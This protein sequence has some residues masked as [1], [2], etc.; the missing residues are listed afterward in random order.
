M[1]QGA[2]MFALVVRIVSVYLFTPVS[3]EADFKST[4]PEYE[5]DQFAERHLL[6]HAP[7]REVI[8]PRTG[9][10]LGSSR[11]IHAPYHF[12]PMF[13]HSG[14][15]L[16]DR[17]V[18]KPATGRLQLPTGLTDLLLPQQ[19]DPK[20]NSFSPVRNPRG[21]EVWCGY[22]HISVRVQR[23]M[24]GFRSVASMFLLGTCPVTR[25]TPVLLYFH[26]NLNDCGSTQMTV[27]GHLVYSNSL[28]YSPLAEGSVIRAVPLHLPIQC[29][30]NRFHYS[31]KVGYVPE[32]HER[33]FLK[34]MKSKRSFRLT[35]CNAEWRH[36]SSEES[37]MLGEPM[38]FEAYAA[39]VPQ[40]YRVFVSS[41]FI[42]PFK[43]PDA[44][45]RFQVIHDFGCMVDSKRQ[46]S[47]SQFF[48][49]EAN[50]LLFS[51]DAFLFP[52]F[53]HK[54]LYLHCNITVGKSIPKPNAKSCTYNRALQRWEELYGS[55]SVCSCCD[56]VCE[57]SEFWPGL[58]PSVKSSITSEP[59][60]V[61]DKSE[62]IQTEA[63]PD[64][65]DRVEE[66]KMFKT[67]A[68][69]SGELDKVAVTPRKE[70]KVASV[71]LTD[72][73]EVELKRVK[74]ISRQDWEEERNWKSLEGTQRIRV[75]EDETLKGMVER[76][77]VAEVEDNM[78]D[79]EMVVV[80]ADE[81]GTDPVPD[82]VPDGLE[83]NEAAPDGMDVHLAEN[84]VTLKK[85]VQQNMS[86]DLTSVVPVNAGV[87]EKVKVIEG[88]RLKVARV[89]VGRMPLKDEEAAF[90]QGYMEPAE[91]KEEYQEPHLGWETSTKDT[92]AVLK[93]S[94][95]AEIT[96]VY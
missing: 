39:F 15:P 80:Q 58:S 61:L 56:S 34:S 67:L 42:T 75:I 19:H 11:S 30:Y 44:T 32:V 33:T 2:W 21:V 12:L 18:F 48:S 66:I 74:D 79:K 59:W 43:D 89:G 4:G 45:P 88:A 29:I 3:T 90:L 8:R 70:D 7:V 51:V 96:D 1:V 23:G 14:V 52:Q 85:V 49:R 76:K 16:V 83:N 94:V 81:K 47:R 71:N 95:P 31:Y 38:Y 40:N 69:T 53:T 36:L 92:L 87:S 84:T 41:C 5:R 13:K 55:S 35:A 26:Y 22:N 91:W 63:L 46:G 54:H 73:V 72:K 9:G 27:N 17:S 10:D 78:S 24:L 86:H 6:G 77:E 65:E 57:V 93:M 37:Y 64:S 62:L 60:R 50:V 82:N 68:V 20:L 25:V 28:N